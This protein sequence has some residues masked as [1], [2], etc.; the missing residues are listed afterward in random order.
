MTLC[1]DM[2]IQSMVRVFPFSHSEQ[3][4]IL[5]EKDS[6]FYHYLNHNRLKSMKDTDT[7]FFLISAAGAFEISIKSL[8]VLV[9]LFR[10]NSN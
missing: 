1:H 8:L 4:D 10:F 7:A 5:F 6:T 2:T 3:D 9:A